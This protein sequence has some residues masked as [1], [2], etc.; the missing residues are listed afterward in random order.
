MDSGGSFDEPSW[1]ESPNG[2]VSTTL[3]EFVVGVRSASAI[4]HRFQEARP[5]AR[6]YLSV[7][8]TLRTRDRKAFTFEFEYAEGVNSFAFQDRGHFSINRDGEV[9]V[10]HSGTVTIEPIGSDA[11]KVSFDQLTVRPDRAG[12]DGPWTPEFIGSGVV[13]GPLRRICSRASDAVYADN[14]VPPTPAPVHDAAWI[15]QFCGGAATE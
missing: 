1:N 3:G 4:Y 2:D 5:G 7:L 12:E 8:H 9:L 11:I 14:Y 10:G 15:S 13:E 6:E